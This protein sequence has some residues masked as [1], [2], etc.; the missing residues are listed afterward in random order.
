MPA[1]RRKCRQ[2]TLI[3]LRKGAVWLKT[4]L[5]QCAWAGSHKKTS[6]LQT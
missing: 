4:T 6:Y 3:R 5:V 1:Q 2:A